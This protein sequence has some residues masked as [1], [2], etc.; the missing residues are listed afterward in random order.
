M[1]AKGESY[2]SKGAM[3]KHEKGEGKMERKMEYG[4]KKMAPKAPVRKKKMK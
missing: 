3:K 2:K 4:A 1:S